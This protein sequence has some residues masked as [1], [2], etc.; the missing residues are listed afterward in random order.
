MQV[1]SHNNSTPFWRVRLQR[2][3][4]RDRAFH[5]VSSG[6]FQADLEVLYCIHRFI[7]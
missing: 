1:L 7:K 4:G 3:E 6:I 2:W 5:R